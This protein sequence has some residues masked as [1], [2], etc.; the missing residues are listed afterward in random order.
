MSAGFS[1]AYDRAL[2][3]AAL[4]H[5]RAVRK[6]TVVPYIIHPVHVAAIVQRHGYGETLVVAAL[7]HDVLEDLDAGDAR[8]Q[9]ALRHAFPRSPLPPQVV[10]R[11]EFDEAFRRFLEQEFDPEVLVLVDA[12]SERKAEQGQE[13]PWIDRKQETLEHLRTAPPDVLALKAADVIHNV[14]SI[15]A[16]MDHHGAAVFRRFKAD[17]SQATWYYAAVAASVADG[18]GDAPIAREA[19]DATR[20]LSAR[21]EAAR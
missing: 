21:A 14:R 19:L 15:L 9:V 13:R 16:D 18:L 20:D 10:G 4:V 11:A 3:V 17:R 7:L 5:E 6:G 1:K 2:V 8:L 12:V